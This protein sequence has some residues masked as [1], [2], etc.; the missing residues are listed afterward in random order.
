MILRKWKN[1]KK[2]QE[3]EIMLLKLQIEDLDRC[4]FREA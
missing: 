3:E 1:W 2:N 4:T